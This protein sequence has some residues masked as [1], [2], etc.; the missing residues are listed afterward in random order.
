MEGQLGPAEPA[1]TIPYLLA[2]WA[3]SA[4][5]SLERRRLPC[6]IA[7]VGSSGRVRLLAQRRHNAATPKR[8]RFG[9]RLRQCLRVIDNFPYSRCPALKCRGMP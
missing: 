8:V 6:G 7:C 4:H 5:H 2:A 3:P 1:W 9:D